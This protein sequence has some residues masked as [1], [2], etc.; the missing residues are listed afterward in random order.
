[1]EHNMKKSLSLTIIFG[2]LMSMFMIISVLAS[3][4]TSSYTPLDNINGID[5]ASYDK[6][7]ADMIARGKQI[8]SGELK[9]GPLS[10]AMRHYYQDGQ[11]WSNDIMQTRGTTI[12]VGGCVVTSFAMIVDSLA[13]IS[14]NPRVVNIKL[15]P[16]ADYFNYTNYYTSYYNLKYTADRTDYSGSPQT[17]VNEIIGYLSTDKPVLIGMYKGT[18]THFVAAYGYNI[19]DPGSGLVAIFDPLLQRDYSQLSQY[20]NDGWAINRIYAYY[21]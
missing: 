13:N 5:F 21:I 3:T 19:Y 9:V 7:N 14:D 11:L 12:G 17:A 1:M 18:S 2:I 4:D 15:G 20:I 10:I 8:L 6:I 16:D